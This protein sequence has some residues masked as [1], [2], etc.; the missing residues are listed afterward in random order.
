MVP[1]VYSQP[2]STVVNMF[3]NVHS[4]PQSLNCAQQHGDVLV[5]TLFKDYATCRILFYDKKC[6][7]QICKG[8]KGVDL[9]KMRKMN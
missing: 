1:S 5:D 4:T 6:N 3:K 9:N 8:K 7:C 2:Q